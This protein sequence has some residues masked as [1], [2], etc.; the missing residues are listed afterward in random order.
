M[1]I[2]TCE[3]NKEDFGSIKVEIAVKANSDSQSGQNSRT[4]GISSNNITNITISISGLDPINVNVV[5]GQTVTQT[6]DDVPLGEQTVQIDLKD[7]QGTILYTQSRSVS[8]E[9]GKTSTPEFQAEEFIPENVTV[10]L[11]SPNGGESWQ[12]GSTQEISWTTSHPS[13]NFTI[14]LYQNDSPQL[15]IINELSS[16]NSFSWTIPNS[17]PTGSNYK[18]RISLSGDT[19]IFS[20]SQTVFSIMPLSESVIAISSPNGGEM[21]VLGFQ[22]DILWSSNDVNG[23][24]KIELYKGTELYQIITENTDNDGNYSWTI[25]SSYETADNY[26]IKISSIENENIFDMSNNNFSLNSSSTMTLNLV[27]PNG[28]EEWE[29]GSTNTISWQYNSSLLTNNNTKTQTSTINS[30]AKN[31]TLSPLIG[32]LLIELYRDWGSYYDLVEIIYNENPFNDSSGVGDFSWTIP[33]L[34]PGTNFK[35]LVSINS[36][37]FGYQSDFSDDRFTI[38]VSSNTLGCTDPY[39]SNYNPDATAD[40]GSCTYPD[41]GSYSLNFDGEDDYVEINEVITFTND[42]SFIGHIKFFSSDAYSNV[43]INGA[44]SNFIRLDGSG[45]EWKLGYNSQTGANHIGNSILPINEWSHIGVVRESGILYFYVDGQLDGTFNEPNN[46]VNFNTIG[47]RNGS[48]NG[49]LDDFSLWTVPLSQS[50]VQQY[51]ENSPTGNEEGIKGLWKF[52]SGVGNILYDH[53][54][55][56][57][58]GNINGATWTEMIY[59]CTDPYADNYNANAN[60]DDGSCSGYPDNGDYSLSF[61]GVNDYVTIQSNQNSSLFENLNQLTIQIKVNSINHYDVSEVAYIFNRVI[62]HW[63]KIKMLVFIFKSKQITGG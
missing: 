48:W 56:S 6:I 19:T 12:V 58:H 59:G 46:E 28:G 33:N 42:F 38:S 21:W 18:I 63:E 7:A 16:T 54:G 24:V 52:N 50:E 41:N 60:V 34:T 47:Y 32:S 8:V 13:E 14:L 43:F 51:F 4:T 23:N 35:I 36:T 62:G 1:L 26:L 49:F 44:G 55:N 45:D 53:S 57:N 11:N 30:E 27:S 2:L 22:Q 61:D 10:E 37:I 5:S 39:A 9:A 20:Q 31:H 15:E 17:V 29:V 25:P 40:D 3:D